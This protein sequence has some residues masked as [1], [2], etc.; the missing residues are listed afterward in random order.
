MLFK[1]LPY[2]T[3]RETFLLAG[4]AR[5][6]QLILAVPVELLDL[7]FELNFQWHDTIII[8]SSIIVGKLIKII[9]DGIAEEFQT[10]TAL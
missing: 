8:L 4:K 1:C 7:H 6:L 3:I 9:N 5:I 10:R 2:Y